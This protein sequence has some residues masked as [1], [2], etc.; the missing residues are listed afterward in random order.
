MP[1]LSPRRLSPWFIEERVTS[2]NP[3]HI[4]D[5]DA[6]SGFP[7]VCLPSEIPGVAERAEFRRNTEVISEHFRV[8]TLNRLPASEA[9]L[10][11]ALEY[12][13]P[14]PPSRSGLG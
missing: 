9:G 2:T 7:L 13:I 12:R 8:M 1:L 11:E 5:T 6:G 3:D 4:G 14:K 10:I